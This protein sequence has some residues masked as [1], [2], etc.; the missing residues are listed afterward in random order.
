MVIAS[1]LLANRPE[2][3]GLGIVWEETSCPLCGNEHSKP[4][5]EAADNARPSRELRFAVVEC[6]NCKLWYTNPRPS[7]A[8]MG[9]FY[10]ESYQPHRRPIFAMAKTKL[11]HQLL[12]RLIGRP[13]LERHRLPWL[14][15]GRLLDFGCGGGE[16]LLRMRD[17]GWKVT[18]LD[19][20][21]KVIRDLR[22][23]FGIP[24]FAGTLPHPDLKP[25]SFDVITMWASLE[26]VHQPLQILRD[27]YELLAPGGRLYLQV[28]NM[29]CWNF[30]VFGKNWYPLDLPRH[31]THFRPATMRQMLET[32][33]YRVKSIRQISH[34]AST[35][36]TLQV[37]K[38]AGPVGIGP[39]LLGLKSINLLWSWLAYLA[40]G[41][42]NIFACAERPS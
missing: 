25:G 2:S 19:Q 7:P 5:M 20:S 8:S 16:F 14:G 1:H 26:H 4:V 36:R 42:D 31:L 30:G 40:G 37:A 27:A 17:Q 22:D 32:A 28:H 9:Q 29:N 6:M 15:Q 12:A 24:G 18:A 39:R 21:E 41:S 23:E 35:K 3:D 13:C 33:G 11:R 10:A 34:P 38:R